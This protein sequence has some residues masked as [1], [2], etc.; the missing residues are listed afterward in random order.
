VDAETRNDDTKK[1]STG[2][3]IVAPDIALEVAILRH[4]PHKLQQLVEELF[5]TGAGTSTEYD[6]VEMPSDGTEYFTIRTPMGEVH[7]ATLS[8]VLAQAQRKRVHWS[9]PFTAPARRR[10]ARAAT[11]KSAR[12]NPAAYVAG[13][14]MRTSRTV[15]S[16]HA[17]KR[18]SS[19]I[20]ESTTTNRPS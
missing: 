9:S 13:V 6:R 5:G 16:Q 15:R 12:A 8:G 2:I 10:I 14:H 4:D 1:H 20:L 17:R 19:P 11:A 18:W 3:A 7:P